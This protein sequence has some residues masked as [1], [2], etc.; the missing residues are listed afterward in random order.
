VLSVFLF[1][2]GGELEKISFTLSQPV[3][4]VKIAIHEAIKPMITI[5]GL[6]PNPSSLREVI[7]VFSKCL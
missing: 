5:M 6:F 4:K 1:P 2:D 3:K 7:A